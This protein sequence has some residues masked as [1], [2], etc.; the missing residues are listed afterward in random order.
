MVG[1]T[2]LRGSM[3]KSEMKER[4]IKALNFYDNKEIHSRQLSLHFQN[5]KIEILKSLC[6]L[7]EWEPE[8]E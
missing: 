7:N 3:K 4:L 1:Y 2:I 6:L 8:N 5:M